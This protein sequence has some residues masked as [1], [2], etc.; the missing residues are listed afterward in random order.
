REYIFFGSIENKK[1][2]SLKPMG[3]SSISYE[4]FTSTIIVAN[5]NLGYSEKKCINYYAYELKLEEIS[6]R[7]LN[8]INEGAIKNNYGYQGDYSE[9][10][11]DIGWNDFMLRNYDAQIGRWIQQDPY[12][13]FPSPYTAMGND[14]IRYV[15][16]TGGFL[17]L[18]A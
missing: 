14:P 1:Q 7:K 9:M 16:P 18:S 3:C 11:D 5:R 6:S 12:Q 15:D 13:E 4:N 17:G 2:L 8:D 10:D